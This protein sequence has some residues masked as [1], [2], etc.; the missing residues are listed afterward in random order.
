MNSTDP[1]PLKRAKDRVTIFELG[2]L[3]FPAWKAGK[4]CRSPFRDDRHSSFSVFD[5]GRKWKDFGSGESGD[6]V[7]FLAKAKGVDK[8][9]AAKELLA[10]ANH[11]TTPAP[12][13][14]RIE[15]ESPAKAS[16]NRM[17]V[18]VAAIWNEGIEY[19]RRSIETQE[20]VEKWRHWPSGTV[21]QL[22]DDGLMGC[23]VLNNRR[24]VAFPVQVPYRDELGLISTFDT[25]LHFRH[26]PADR[27]ARVSW[28]YLP[29][30]KVHGVNC[31]AMPFVIGAGFIP[32]A[33]TVVVTEG[34]WDA[35]TICA[36]AG[37]L[38]SDAAW[39]ERVSVFAT[40]GAGAWRPLIDLWS[41]FWP[42]N[43]RFVLFADG[44]DAGATWKASGG[45]KDAL[46]RLGHAVRIVRPP[47]GGPK[48]LNDIHRAQPI[49]ADVIGEWIS[50][51][52]HA[53]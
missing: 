14:R 20:G 17:P 36:A 28:S 1:S 11:D 23:P 48:D 16:L 34:Q 7:D 43:A 26:K 44:D 49:P 2:A 40:R 10:Q 41:S 15:A 13:H 45:F 31:S 30:M 19:I 42:R 25:G 46:C 12:I 21:R 47:Q 27:E 5:D 53:A 39:P 24:G 8:S 33:E 51:W 35:I 38:E 18:A 4:S 9:A 50:E 32:Y 3:Y 22:A 6:A 37:W 52:S 29:N